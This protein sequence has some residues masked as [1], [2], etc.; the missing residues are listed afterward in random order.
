MGIEASEAQK[1][2]PSCGSKIAEAATR[3]DFCK[4]AVGR[5]TGCG[6]WIVEGTQCFDC[7]KST[8]RRVVK[9]APKVEREESAP[10][11]YRGSGTGLLVPLLLRQVLV[12]AWGGSIVLATAASG[13]APVEKALADRGIHPPG[14]PSVLWTVAGVL[15]LAVMM[16]SRL[17]RRHRAVHTAYFGQPLEF[18]T[19]VGAVI[20]NSILAVIV[21]AMTAGLGTPWLYAR[22]VRSSYRSCRV[23][24]R[25]G[26]PLEW[27]GSGEAVLGR[28]FL[29]LLLLPVAVATAGFGGIAI[30][31]MWISWEQ[32][33]LKVSDRNGILQRVRF[34]GTFGSYFARAALGW[35][36]TVSTLGL[37]WPWAK[38][39]DWAWVA[40]HTEAE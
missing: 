6:A 23:P 30:S 20:G 8:A 33:H 24:S 18:R 11:E 29:M 35:L 21:L 10:V 12:L 14:G 28:F 1:D 22:Q 5:C 36:V 17:V 38:T 3:C 7:G 2:C 27:D 13:V 40:A 26:R 31:W 32:R 37:Y 19:S 25:G 4:S 9:Q 16:T 34:T 39:A 15:L